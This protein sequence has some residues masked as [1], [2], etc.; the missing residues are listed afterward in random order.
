MPVVIQNTA[1]LI[2]SQNLP[3]FPL[4][5]A[6]IGYKSIATNDNVIAS[7]EE[8]G[9]PAQGAVNSLTYEA[10]RPVTLPATWTVDYGETV[11]ADYVGI[12]NHSFATD[13]CTVD[14][15][16]SLDGSNWT[17]LA[18]LSPGTGEPIMILSA[19]TVTARYW[20]LSVDGLSV[21]TV[22][23][24]YIG[25]ALAM[26]RPIYGGHRPITLNRNSKVIGNKSESG[27][28]LGV[29]KIRMGNS[30]TYEWSHLKADWYR[31]NF[32]PFAKTSTTRGFFIAWNPQ[33][34]PDEVGFG[35]SKSEPQPSNMGINNY[36]E[37]SLSVDGHTNG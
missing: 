2:D 24:I 7:S 1:A 25:E 22:G 20:R 11:D 8:A 17:T 34:H 26:Q 29:T 9:F 35:L 30:A 6:R 37:V 4:K 36:M 5:N 3:P 23:V 31:T 21:P 18:E 12:A 14:I 15:E 28:I 27:N 19:Q 33:E 13:R 16:Y 32:D 10:W